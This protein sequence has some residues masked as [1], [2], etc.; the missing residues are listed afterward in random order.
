M[1]TRIDKA[2]D[3]LYKVLIDECSDKAVSCN[4]FINCYE[5]NIEFRTR[6]AD[7]L[8]SEGVSMKNIKGNFIKK[9]RDIEELIF[10]PRT[11][12]ILRGLGVDTVERLIKHTEVELLKTNGLGKKCLTEIKDQLKRV[13]LMLGCR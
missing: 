5:R 11:E 2:L 7:S 3:N 4:I 9:E 6:N 12:A 1:N 10:T 8:R 13:N